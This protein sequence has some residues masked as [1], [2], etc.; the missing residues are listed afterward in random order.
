MN[1]LNNLDKNELAKPY[2]PEDMDNLLG[3]VFKISSRIKNISPLSI[4]T[5]KAEMPDME[6]FTSALLSTVIKIGNSITFLQAEVAQLNAKL[7]KMEGN[8]GN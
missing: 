7:S 6:G 5:G 1:T 4:M 2:K 8:N 3:E